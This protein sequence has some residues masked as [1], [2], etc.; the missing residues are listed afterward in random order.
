MQCLRAFLWGVLED[1]GTQ[2]PCEADWQ[3]D[4]I[5]AP[6]RRRMLSVT[7]ELKYEWSQVFDAVGGAVVARVRAGDTAVVELVAILS[8]NRPSSE[9]ARP[10]TDVRQGSHTRRRDTDLFSGASVRHTCVVSRQGGKRGGHIARSGQ[11]K[12]RTA[13]RAETPKWDWG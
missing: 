4:P 5:A 12:T 2:L 7:A 13:R 10:L 8:D 9:P 11:V 6:E 3:I 1:A